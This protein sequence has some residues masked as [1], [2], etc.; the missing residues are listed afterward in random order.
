MCMHQFSKRALLVNI[1][2]TFGYL[3]CLILWAWIGVLFMPLL[4][5]S[6]QFEHVFIPTQTTKPTAA[7]IPDSFSPV[8]TII[9]LG[10]TA[11]IMIITV[12]A[13]L[14]APIAIA[15]AGKKVTTKTADTA[16]PLLTHH[17]VLPKKEKRRLTAQLIKLA[18]LLFVILPVGISFSGLA[19]DSPLPFALVLLISSVLALLAVFWFSLQYIFAQLLNVDSSKLV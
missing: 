9:A 13:L 6:K 16:L 12:I 17:K 3:F 1:F 18:K 7:A 11:V 14:R 5:E 4:L 19:I 8:V 10:I 2:G 15:R